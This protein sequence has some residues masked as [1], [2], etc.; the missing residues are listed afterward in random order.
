MQKITPNLWFD[1]KAEEV[2]NFYTSF[3]KN[4]KILNVTRYTEEGAQ[5]SR[6]P[7]AR[8]IVE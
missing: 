5:V 8:A 1:D 4:S 3:F 2:V 6:R 7:R